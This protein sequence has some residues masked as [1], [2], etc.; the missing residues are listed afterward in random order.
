MATLDRREMD[1]FWKGVFGNDRPVEIEIGS[2]T[3]TFLLAAAGRHPGVNYLGI[4]ASFSRATALE[5]AV[6]LRGLR[7]TIV[8]RAD[9]ACVLHHIIPAASVSAYHIYFPDP[10]WKRRH[11][12][13]RLFTAQFVADLA[14]TLRPEGLVYTATDVELVSNL[15]FKAITTESR[16]VQVPGLRSPRLGLTR[17]EE[18]G[19]NRGHIIR[20]AAFRKQAA[21]VEATQNTDQTSKAAPI[22]PAESP[23]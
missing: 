23:S 15:I 13:R 21:Q 20:D 22:T 3:G 10:W 8:L 12:R 18:K 14:R 17:F 7:N 16:F 2:G 5:Q 6:C 19:L 11:F 1:T 9:A 4:E